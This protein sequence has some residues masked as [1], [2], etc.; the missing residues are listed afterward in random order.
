MDV[1]NGTTPPGSPQERYQ[2]VVTFKVA[3]E[4]LSF[5]RFCTR[6][7]RVRNRMMVKNAHHA[8]G[9]VERGGIKL[10]PNIQLPEG[11]QVR[12]SW[13]EAESSS[14]MPYD[15][16]PLTE[17]DVRADIDWAMKEPRTT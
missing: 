16:Q 5:R 3:S 9:V 2:P 17:D 12:I 10:P 13:E 15:R 6:I 1:T 7:P 11:T 14:V 8:I 4:V